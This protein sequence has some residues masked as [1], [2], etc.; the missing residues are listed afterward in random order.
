MRNPGKYLRNVILAGGA[1]LFGQSVLAQDLAIEEIVVTASKRSQSI[2]DVS[3]SVSAFNEDDLKLGG[4]EDVSRLEHM[5]PGLR[6]GQSGHEVRLAM[7][8]TR[9][10][11]V[12][13]EAEQVVGIF[14]DGVYVPTTTQALGAY[15]DVERIEVLR[16]P[17][18]TLYGR[19]TFG[20]TINIITNEPSF[21][22]VEYDV[23]GLLGAYSRYRVEGMLNLPL[24]DTFAVRLAALSD[25]HDGYIENTNQPGTA[26]DLKDK[27][28]QFF[29]ATLRW[30]PTDTFDASLRVAS[31][32]VDS[33]G[34]AIWGYQQIGGYVG[35]VYRQGHQYAPA[36]ASGNFDQGPW[37]VS[38]NL[39]SLADVESTSATLSLNW[40]WNFATLK[41][42]YNFTDFEGQQQYDSDYS[43]GG[44]ALNNGFTGWD[45]AQETWSAEVQLVS[46]GE[47]PLEWLLGYYYYELTANWNWNALENGEWIE[48][49][50]DRQ[51]DYV[52]DSVGYFANASYGLTDRLRFIGGV[53]YAEDTKGQRDPLDWSVWPPVP[54]PGDGEKGEWDKTLW[55][56][57]IEYDLTPDVM[58][59]GVASTGYRA[60]GINFIA[61]NVP[62]SYAPE[63]VTAFEAGLKSTLQDGRL[64]VNVAAF[65]NQYRDMHAQSFIYLGGGGVSEF[66]ENG[67]EL[68]AQGLEVEVKWLPAENWDVSG[69]VSFLDA[70]FGEYNV[71]RLAGLGNAGGRQDLNDPQRPLL[72]LEGWAPA[73]SPEFSTGLQVS[74]DVVLGNG[75]VLTPF[76]QT[77]YTGKYYA[78]D[79][80][81]PGVDQGAHT[82]S[83]LRLIWTSANSRIQAQAF[84]LNVE[85]EAVLNRVVVFNPGGTVDLASLQAHWNNPR[86]WGVSVTYSFY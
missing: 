32:T 46:S 17:Q 72:S 44:D 57:G 16:G 24:G 4:I 29:R 43:D 27:D 54:R 60:G 41:V 74:H 79:V 53:R 81:V 39:A 19:N 20:G 23:S 7:R 49:Y 15:V 35:G 25:T 5:V 65:A 14:E 56:A 84:V 82:K 9:T 59:Y 69:W 76:L 80:N 2:Q 70:E 52:S 30:Q 6:F 55:K 36:D 66:T 38:R 10:N 85:D 12:G 21:E 22:N 37:K 68:D 71:S 47:G 78:H 77:T 63:E 73:L 3:T 13:T 33:N 86:T 58:A 50:W 42:I 75:S 83:D 8:G 45:S 61:P 40:D 67:G 51:G 31:S 26:D 28:M 34:S 11:N 18:G 48:P 64:V 62:L 1:V